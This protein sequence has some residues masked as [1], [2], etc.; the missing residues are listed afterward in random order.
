MVLPFFSFR[1]LEKTPSKMATDFLKSVLASF[2]SENELILHLVDNQLVMV[3]WAV[4]LA[5]SSFQNC[6][7]PSLRLSEISFEALTCML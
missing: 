1:K 3:L 7:M 4:L 2:F 6:Q 5:A